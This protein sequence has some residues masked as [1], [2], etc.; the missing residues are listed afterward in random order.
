MPR[1][2]VRYLFILGD[3]TESKDYHSARLVNKLVSGLLRCYRDGGLIKIYILRGNHDGIDPSCPFFQFLG[4]YP[5]I[6]YISTPFMAP[7]DGRD[8]LLLPHT[9]TPTEAWKSVNLHLADF[10]FTH[11]TVQGAVAENGQTLSGVPASIFAT[12]HRA[13]I[14]SGDVHVPQETGRVEYIGAPYPIRFGDKF[15][16][17]AVLI[18]NWSK[19]RDLFF[20]SLQRKIITIGAS[21]IT[22]SDLGG[23]SKGDQIKVRIK[24][25]PAEYTDWQKCKGGVTKACSGMGIELCGVELERTASVLPKPARVSLVRTNSQN[26]AFRDF[27]VRNKLADESVVVGRSLLEKANAN[28]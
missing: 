26:S 3:L 11:V 4:Q 6:H 1:H 15:T 12:A 19:P 8:V 14:Y 23:L 20:P 27:C 7:F 24:L 17:R 16:G 9:T 10:I 25:T 22:D 5:S 18:E 13:K 28:K 21:G 2:Q